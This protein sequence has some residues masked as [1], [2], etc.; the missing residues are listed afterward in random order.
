MRRGGTVIGIRACCS[1]PGYWEPGAGS[2]A[3]RAGGRDSALTRCAR[4]APHRL[5]TLQVGASTR[6]LLCSS[7]PFGCW[8]AQRALVSFLVE[9]LRTVLTV[10]GLPFACMYACACGGAVLS[11][12]A[13]A[14]PYFRDKL[15][16]PWR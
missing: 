15:D 16:T 2:R 6:P 12:A 10:A 5:E 7:L 14:A 13:G 3:A 4:S 1:Y 8:C 9:V 11:V